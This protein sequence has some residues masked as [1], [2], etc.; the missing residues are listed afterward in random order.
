MKIKSV[1]FLKSGTEADLT[2]RIPEICV[3]GRSNVGKSS[4]I[5]Y[6][7]NSKIA[8]TSSTPGRTQLINYFEINNGE[9][10]LVDL[11]GYGFAKTNKSTQE[12]WGAMIEPYL[13]NNSNLKNILVLLDCRHNPSIEDR[14]LINYL[15]FYRLPFTIVA[16][17]T[18]KLSRAELQRALSSLSKELKVG[19]GNI[20]PVSALKRT[21]AEELL[22]R[23]A[24]FLGESQ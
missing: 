19:V 18:D 10:L 23:I 7:T 12:K 16:T 21:G 20:Y 8:R 14:D 1:K 15:L 2:F 6:L 5:N 17:K 24:Q 9:F 22:E 11:P 13:Q 3:V 4:L